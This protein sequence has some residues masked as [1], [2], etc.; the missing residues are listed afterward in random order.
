MTGM[1]SFF[2]S[3]I[4]VLNFLGGIGAGAHVQKNPPTVATFDSAGMKIKVEELLNGLNV[5]WG[6][7]FLPDGRI[8]LSERNGDV[9]IFDPAKKQ[10]A[11]VESAP[12]VIEKGQGGLLDVA[13]H[14]RFA[15][16]H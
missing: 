11:P 16:N 13:L 10:I 9:K 12:A 1:K 15:E 4:L 14:P 2:A 3:A 5:I 7:D 6:M 8:L